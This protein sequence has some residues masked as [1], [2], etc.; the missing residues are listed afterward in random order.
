MNR[1]IVL[2]IV[3]ATLAGSAFANQLNDKVNAMK[4][5]GRRTFT[6]LLV[7]QSGSECPVVQRTFFQGMLE[8]NAVWNVSCGSKNYGIVFYDDEA[9]TTRV[10]TCPALK[11]LGAPNCFKKF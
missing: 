10:M 1:Q 5:S 2:G 4:E 11:E 9:N 8:K 3:F 6:G 7:R